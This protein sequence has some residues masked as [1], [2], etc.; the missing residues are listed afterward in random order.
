MEQ[1]GSSNELTGF[2]IR[3]YSNLSL[4]TNH[5]FSAATDAYAARA[6]L[7]ARRTMASSPV[8]EAET[9]AQWHL[10]YA[11]TMTGLQHKAHE[12]SLELH[13]DHQPPD[14]AEFIR[15]GLDWD[16]D[17]L[18]NLAIG[19]SPSA[20]WARLMMFQQIDQYGYAQPTYE[21][22]TETI[23]HRQASPPE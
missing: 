15:P 7:Y 18:K 22:A 1:H 3:A 12:Q 8:D 16:S 4:L 23:E 20:D 17:S 14:W 11:Q 2:L 9:L 21:A 5:F 6:I 10:L 19:K 13:K